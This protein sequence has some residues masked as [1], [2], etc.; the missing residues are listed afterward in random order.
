VAHLVWRTE[1]TT[2][3]RT[4]QVRWKDPATGKPK[5]RS[6]GAIA[7]DTAE[8]IRKKVEQEDEGRIER[9]RTSTDVARALREF[10][11][12]L[13]FQRR[14][15]KTIRFYHERLGALFTYLAQRAQMARWRPAFLEDYLRAHPAWSPRR[16][17]MEIYAARRFLR[18]ARARYREMPDFVGDTKGPRVE[19]KEPPHYTPIQLARILAAARGWKHERPVA[20]AALGGLSYSDLVVLR[21]EQIDLDAGVITG[22]RVKTGKPYVVPILPQLREVLVRTGIEKQKAGLVCDLP[23]K[24][25]TG[26][27]K[28]RRILVAAGVIDAPPSDVHGKAG[29]P[30]PRRKRPPER[31]GWHKLRHSYGALLDAG[32]ASLAEIRTAMG[33][34]AQSIMTLRYMHSDQARIVAAGARAGKVF[35][36]SVAAARANEKRVRPKR[37]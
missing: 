35:E 21:R 36:E 2:G 11:E 5:A 29:T 19:L 30:P 16:I 27:T 20:L 31:W 23:K 32:G 37:A 14:A 8:A 18:W 25:G 6:L 3:R 9:L 12:H 24:A 13:R 4:V 17:Q 28:L 7:P 33:H 34:S 1:K 22:Q 26:R 10:E 15:A